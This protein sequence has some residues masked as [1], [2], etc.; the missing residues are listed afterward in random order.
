MPKVKCC[1]GCT[2]DDKEA[3]TGDAK[4]GAKKKKKKKKGKPAGDKLA[5]TSQ[6]ANS[7]PKKQTD[8]PTIPI[9]DL[10][11]D[12]NFPLGEICEYKIGTDEYVDEIRISF[13]VS[14]SI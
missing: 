6:A 7:A 4:V 3:S 8:P 2:E 12:G 11:P 9:A 1:L 13:G 5:A 10:F 14:S